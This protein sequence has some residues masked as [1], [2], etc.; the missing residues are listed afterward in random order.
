MVTKGLQL[1]EENIG[2]ILNIWP[3]KFVAFKPASG[4]CLC[5]RALYCD[6][7][8]GMSMSPVITVI[9][10]LEHCSPVTYGICTLSFGK[11]AAPHPQHRLLLQNANDVQRNK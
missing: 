4:L 9:P 8:K 2:K 1:Q 3:R 11:P 6:V 7:K 5:I 10:H